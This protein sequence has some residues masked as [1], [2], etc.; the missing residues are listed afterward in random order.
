[1]Y[2]L[3]F[4][5]IILFKNFAYGQTNNA[6]ALHISVAPAGRIAPW[7]QTDTSQQRPTLK[8]MAPTNSIKVIIPSKMVCRQHVNTFFIVAD[9]TSTSEKDSNTTG[10]A[11][12]N[13]EAIPPGAG[14]DALEL[15]LKTRGRKI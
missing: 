9:T 7:N 15:M 13:L 11:G 2:R 5:L 4:C 12:F 14:T 1:M 10:Q 6:L 3:L 8:I